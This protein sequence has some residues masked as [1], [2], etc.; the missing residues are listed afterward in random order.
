MH[1]TKLPELGKL[2]T[3]GAGVIK[4][5]SLMFLL[6]LQNYQWCPS[7]VKSIGLIYI[8]VVPNN[9][10]RILDIYVKLTECEKLSEN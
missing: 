5:N 3:V 7:N 2:L 1:N 8:S 6:C 10:A 4:P 9:E